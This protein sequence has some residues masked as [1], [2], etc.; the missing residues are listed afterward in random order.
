M[1]LIVGAAVVFGAVIL[2]VATAFVLTAPSKAPPEAPAGKA[3]AQAAA[4]PAEF[5]YVPFGSVVANLSEGRLTRYLQVSII[6]KA[7]KGSGE[8]L[9]KAMAGGEKAVFQNWLITYLS[10]KKL[11]EVGGAVAI[12]RLQREILEGFNNILAQNGGKKLE[13]VLFEE[14]NIQ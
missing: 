3:S 4:A 1:L 11:E 5:E 12:T 9:K 8:A 10:D 6:L 14:F 13:A 2:G 7:Q